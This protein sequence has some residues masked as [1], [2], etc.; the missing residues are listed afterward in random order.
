[1]KTPPTPPPSPPPSLT[2]PT[3]L[4]MTSLKNPQNPKTPKPQN[5]IIILEDNY[6]RNEEIID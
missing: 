4:L 6:K 3:H 2:P 1:M 5:P